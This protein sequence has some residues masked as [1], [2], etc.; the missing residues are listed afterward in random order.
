MLNDSLRLELRNYRMI[1]V[2]GPQ[3][4]L[5]DSADLPIRTGGAFSG[6]QPVGEGVI[7]RPREVVPRGYVS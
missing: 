6:T 5:G 7:S 3:Y 1:Q 2:E 4:F